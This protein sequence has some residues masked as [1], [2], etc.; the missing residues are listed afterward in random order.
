MHD[1]KPEVSKSAMACMTE[2]CKV[3]CN[4]DIDHHIEL[5]VDCMAH[6]D[7]VSTAVQKLSST[8]FVAEVTGPALAIMVP[9]LVRALN[10][11]SA[12]VMR[13]TSVIANNLFKLV[14]NPLDAGQFL[15]QLLPG[16]DRIIDAAA[17]PEIRALASEAKAT[18]VKSADLEHSRRPSHTSTAAPIT[19]A[20]ILEH[21]KKAI[22][23]KGL[24]AFYTP[25]LNMIAE[26]IGCLIKK[27]YYEMSQ[28]T[29][30]IAP[31]L[32]N[33]LLEAE[34]KKFVEETHTYYNT[35]YEVFIY[36]T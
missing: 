31:Y 17:F 35:I 36:L 7:H 30:L 10:D 5:L 6:P 14:R 9:L 1:T 15:P 11:R 29:L 13:S 25:T 16:F 4:P 34:I 22:T 27:E 32:A 24:S 26:H 19:A 18:L 3:V 20:S 33:I 2:L 28:W 23:F 8:T 21:V 12:A